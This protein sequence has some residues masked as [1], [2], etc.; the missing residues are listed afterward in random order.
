M[1]SKM[2]KTDEKGLDIAK[3]PSNLEREDTFECYAINI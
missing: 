3:F 1:P 2:N